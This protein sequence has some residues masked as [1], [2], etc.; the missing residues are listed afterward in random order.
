MSK[1]SDYSK[2]KGRN[3]SPPFVQVPHWLM[4]TEAWRHLSTDGRALYLEVKMRF[5]GSNNGTIGLGVHEAAECLNISKSVAHRAFL[6]VIDRGFIAVGT[7]SSFGT[8]GRKAAEW[9][10]TEYMDDRTGASA[11]KEFMGWKHLACVPPAGHKKN[12]SVPPA[13][14]I[15]PPAGHN[16]IQI[17]DEGA[18]RP[19][20]GT[21]QAK[22]AVSASPQR[23]TYRSSHVGVG[24]N[25]SEEPAASEANQNASAPP[26]V[27]SPTSKI[28]DLSKRSSRTGPEEVGSGPRRILDEVI[29]MIR[30]S[31]LD[32]EAYLDQLRALPGSE[33][34]TVAKRDL[35]WKRRQA[36]ATTLVNDDASETLGEAAGRLLASLDAKRVST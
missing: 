31:E 13:G 20:S 29:D 3:K 14:H 23:D 6:E 17:P 11:S 16:G 4:K 34:F 18:L 8:N 25:Q 26:P 30:G 15:V 9:R 32:T 1:G 33:Q 5:N 10:L 24:T 2:R 12:S 28:F 19:P 22:N 36:K 7:P 35:T 27:Q 21:Q